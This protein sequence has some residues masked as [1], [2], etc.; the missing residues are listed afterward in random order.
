MNRPDEQEGC[1]PPLADQQ[2]RGRVAEF[3]QRRGGLCL[4]GIL[5]ATSIGFAASMK[6]YWKLSQDGLLYV[7]S[8][9]NL[10]EG[11]GLQLFGTGNRAQ[12]PLVSVYMAVG[13][14]LPG[15]PAV[16][17]QL[18]QLAAVLTAVVLAYRLLR[19]LQHPVAALVV[20]ALVG[21]NYEF[22]RNATYYLSE[23]LFT[24]LM[25]AALLVGL[26]LFLRGKPAWRNVLLFGVLAVLATLTRKVGLAFFPAILFGC[27]FGKHA[28]TA[29]RKNRALVAVVV[30]LFATPYLAWMRYN[31]AQPILDTPL[32]IASS[33]IN[34]RLYFGDEDVSVASFV[35]SLPRRLATVG[36]WQMEGLL[37][38]MITPASGIKN[39][40]DR[41]LWPGYLLCIPL[42]GACLWGWWRRFRTERGLLEFFVA[43][44]VVAI[45]LHPLN[46]G[47]RLL[48][49]LIAVAWLYTITALSALLGR[50]KGRGTA[51]F[52]ADGVLLIAAAAVDITRGL[53]SYQSFRPTHGACEDA[54]RIA[55][56]LADRPDV[57]DSQIRLWIPQKNP[58]ITLC[59]L[60][61]RPLLNLA[62]SIPM[63]EALD[64]SWREGAKLVI[65]DTK[66]SPFEPPRFDHRYKPLYRGRRLLV[67]ERL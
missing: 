22:T 13:F 17:V 18:L 56:L 33:T 25:L 40:R 10:A 32:D 43:G 34:M 64:R 16:N 41:L 6:P 30:L 9:K 35:Q 42:A 54:E 36:R 27:L 46:E 53:H 11:E 24:V 3:M 28:R 51:A 19:R 44:Y 8:A 39:T 49:P 20:A 59:I 45:L 67:L 1:L 48:L 5:V 26:D 65:L 52:V 38:A 61:N 12:P 55:E 7:G 37:R 23:P 57:P 50:W 29:S 62:P 63:Q 21:L 2:R 66:A 47:S 60:T 4:A 31:A 14:L 58:P 15:S